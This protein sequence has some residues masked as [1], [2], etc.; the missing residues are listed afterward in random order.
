MKIPANYRT[1]ADSQYCLVLDSLL[2]TGELI[3]SR[4]GE[5]FSLTDTNPIAFTSLPLVTLR[6]TA[7]KMA[8]KEMEWFLSGDVECPKELL[9]WWEKQLSPDGCYL[10]GYPEQFRYADTNGYDQLAFILGGLQSNPN[11][12]RLIMTAWNPEEMAG[13]TTINQNPN[14]PT[15]CHSTLIQFFVRNDKLYANHYQRSAD[16]LLGVPHNW[17]Q[18]WAFL[19]FLAYHAKLK[20]GHLR[21]VFGDVHLYQEESHM[22][23]AEEILAEDPRANW[24]NAPKLDYNYSGKLD[25]AGLPAFLADDFALLG[26]ILEPVTITKPILL[27]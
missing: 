9:P 22:D 24:G 7:W 4:A 14:T 13:I 25:H 10:H 11:S 15:T 19:Q 5:T 3:A 21:W 2:C 6:K 1:H 16:I 18:H 26:E 17:V 20:V 12:R 27:V 8:L 23:T